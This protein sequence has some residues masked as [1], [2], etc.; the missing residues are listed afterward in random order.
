MQNEMIFR[1]LPPQEIL[2]LL[3]GVAKRLTDSRVLLVLH[4]LE[5]TCKDQKKSDCESSSVARSSAATLLTQKLQKHKGLSKTKRVDDGI[6]FSLE[7]TPAKHIFSLAATSIL[8]SSRTT[9]ATVAGS[10]E[11]VPQHCHSE[12]LTSLPSP[13]SAPAVAV[14]GRDSSAFSSLDVGS[15]DQWRRP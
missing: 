5:I 14:V 13:A 7:P 8:S 9:A 11:E 2:Q 6:P 3:I 12:W 15:M 4:V 1:N 10:I